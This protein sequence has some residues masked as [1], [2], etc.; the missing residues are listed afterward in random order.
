MGDAITNFAPDFQQRPSNSDET[1]LEALNLKHPS[2]GFAVSETEEKPLVG[3]EGC[4]THCKTECRDTCAI[5][6]C[7]GKC[8]PFCPKSCCYLSGVKNQFPLLDP[9]VQES[10]M[11][12]MAETF[13]PRA[14]KNKCDSKC[15]PICCERNSTSASFKETDFQHLKSE[16]KNDADLFRNAMSWFGM[17]K[18]LNMMY[19]M[20]GNIHGSKHKNFPLTMDYHKVKGAQ[21]TRPKSLGAETQIIFKQVGVAESPKDSNTTCPK[22]CNG[23]CSHLCPQRC[24]HEKPSGPTLGKVGRPLH[25]QPSCSWFCS[26]SCPTHCCSRTK[27]PPVTAKHPTQPI[28]TVKSSPITP[29]QIL[30][31]VVP[32]KPYSPCK[33]SCPAYCYPRCLE[34]CC[35]RGDLPKERTVAQGQAKHSYDNFFTK[36]LTPSKLTCP[37][38]CNENCKPSCPVGCCVRLP[39][40][41]TPS[42]LAAT[43]PVHSSAP[44]CPG[45]CVSECFPACTM[46]CCRANIKKHVPTENPTRKQ[47][48]PVPKRQ[49]IPLLPAAS[50]CHPGCSRSCYPNCDETCCRATSEHSSRL[51][52]ST[53][54]VG[55]SPLNI[56]APCPSE[57]RPFNCLYYCHHECCLQGKD[58]TLFKSERRGYQ[59]PVLQEK[60]KYLSRMR[61][62]KTLTSRSS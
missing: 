52:S 13:C 30:P 6:C 56:K 36:Q 26:N 14:C 38:G 47:N 24:C 16:S 29:S 5:R 39:P 1:N 23:T 61:K 17:M 31:S 10:F 9:K 21:P 40:S 8:Q 51:S 62:I 43:S 46:S 33:A 54:V 25:C 35:R 2:G 41:P 34:N 3:D 28:K 18:F 58:T 20:Y 4:P 55:S 60:R 42:Q 50:V 59:A 15:P 48:Q 44:L 12:T 37:A 27:I 19:R 49:P 32:A 11:K 45:D 57:C 22:F 7:L 53:Q